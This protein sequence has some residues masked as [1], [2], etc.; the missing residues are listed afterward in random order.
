MKI[1]VPNDNL[2]GKFSRFVITEVDC[3]SVKKSFSKFIKCKKN[4]YL[5]HISSII[6]VLVK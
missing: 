6:N 1:L 3:I 4:E 2:P 5:Y